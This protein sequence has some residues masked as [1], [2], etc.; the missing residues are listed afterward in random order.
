MRRSIVLAAVLMLA[1]AIPAGAQTNLGIGGGLLLPVG[2]FGDIADASPYIGARWE[3][4]DVN[5]L[6]QVAVMSFLVQGGFAFLQTDSDL[7]DALDALGD[8]DDGSYFDIGLGARMYSAASPLFVSVGGNY[9][10]LDAPGPG[11]S[12]NGAGLY[13][14]AG[15]VIDTPAVKVDVEGRANVVFIADDNLTHFQILAAF[16]FPFE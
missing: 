9:V 10:N 2:D 6:G 16:G 12:E 13:A 1:A 7:E 15:L 3:V 14:G 8:T 4:Q 11:D 5:V